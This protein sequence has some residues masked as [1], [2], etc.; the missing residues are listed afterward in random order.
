LLAFTAFTAFSTELQAVTADATVGATEGETANLELATDGGAVVAGQGR[1]EVLAG[2]KVD[3]GDSWMNVYDTYHRSPR[4]NG[5][6]FS[7]SKSQQGDDE[8]AGELHRE[9]RIK[10]NHE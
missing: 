6:G 4:R 10:K 1:L 7:T 2:A 9:R 5:Q 8:F 3:V